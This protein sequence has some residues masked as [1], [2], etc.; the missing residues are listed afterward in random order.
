MKLPG[1]LHRRREQ[2][3]EPLTPEELAEIERGEAELAAGQG[4]PHDEVRRWLEAWG[5]SDK[6]PPP[7]WLK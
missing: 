1:F 3:E 6:I 7:P 2:Q 5:K 4:V